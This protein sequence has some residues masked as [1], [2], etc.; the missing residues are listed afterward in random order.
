[1]PLDELVDRPQPFN[2]NERTRHVLPLEFI[3][4]QNQLDSLEVFASN[5][6]LKIKEK[7]TCIMKFNF[8][9]TQDFPPELDIKGF[10]NQVEVIN[11][12]KLLGI[13]ITNNLKWAGNTNYLCK[14]AYKNM[15]RLRRMKVLDVDPSVMLDVYVK[16]IRSILELAVPAW[17][18]GLTVKQSA[19]IERVQRV[20][21][22]IILSDSKTGKSF[23][24]YYN[25]LD[26]L[27]LEN[28]WS[29]RKKLFLPFS[30][31]TLKSSVRTCL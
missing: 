3:S 11:E 19:D 29:R 21:V 17:H 26:K 20:A 6:L 14:K 15:W 18:S 25:A 1:M 27:E 8:S 2:F 31:K 7:K 22:H 9:R 30:K 13:I 5:K 12:T 16:E 10:K 24:S 4:L 28:L 23:F